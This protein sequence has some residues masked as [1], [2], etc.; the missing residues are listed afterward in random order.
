V[1]DNFGL[2][3]FTIAR[4]SAQTP[5]GPLSPAQAVRLRRMLFIVVDSGRGP[6]DANW[7]QRLEGPSGLELV[8]AITDTAMDAS[9]RQS[10]TAFDATMKNWRD[11]M[12]RWR[13]G[14]SAAEVQ[15]LRGAG[16]WDCH[17]VQFFIGRVAFDQ[18]VPGR[19]A[20][21]NA[22]P[23]RFQLPVDVVDELIAAGGDAL[24]QHPTYRAFLKDRV[25]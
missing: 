6:T 5:Y 10:Y 2:S 17:D 9:V 18:L 20:K 14:L 7:A 12:V 3:G 8:G 25:R 1:A 4:E 13:C 22:V 16:P 24:R 11:A 23:T 21:L 15:R 19:A